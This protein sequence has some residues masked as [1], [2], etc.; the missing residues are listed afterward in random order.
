MKQSKIEKKDIKEKET[1][2]GEN[3]VHI[4]IIMQCKF[5]RGKELFAKKR[6]I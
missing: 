2:E 6:E 1:E 4:A 5:K 3:Y